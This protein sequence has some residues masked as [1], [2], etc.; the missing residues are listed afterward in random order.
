MIY[1]LKLIFFEWFDHYFKPKILTDRNKNTSFTNTSPLLQKEVTSKPL[2][3]STKASLDKHTHAITPPNTLNTS[4]I[5]NTSNTITKDKN[6]RH[7]ISN[8]PCTKTHPREPY[9]IAKKQMQTIN[10]TMQ[11]WLKVENKEV[12]HEEFPP[13]ESIIIKL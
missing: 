9:D 1:K 5:P 6:T 7:Q 4:H 10:R 2:T 11:N 8:F 12:V 13:Y 3:T